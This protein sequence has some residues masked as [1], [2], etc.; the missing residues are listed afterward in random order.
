MRSERVGTVTIPLTNGKL[1]TLREVSYTPNCDSN[2]ISLGQLR[3]S[4]ITFHDTSDAMVLMRDGELIARAR[5]DPN[6]FV[7]DSASADKAM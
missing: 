3:E 5:R 4:R 1:F 7:L 6:L 2:L